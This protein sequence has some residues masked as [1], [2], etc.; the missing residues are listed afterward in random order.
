MFLL[1]WLLPHGV[2]EIPAI[3]V[4]GQAGLVIAYAL[5]G[6]GSRISRAERLRASLARRGDAGRRARGDAGVGGHGGG[7][8]FA[9]SRAGDFL[10]LEDRVRAGG[11]RVAYAISG[12]GGARSGRAFVPARKPAG[13]P[14]ADREVRPTT[15]FMTG[16]NTLVIRTPEG[17]E[18]A[19]P[20]AGPFS[21]M[22]AYSVDLA[23]MGQLRAR[24]SDCSLRC[25]S[26]GRISAG[27]VGVAGYFV[28]SLVYMSLAEWFW[29]GQTVGKRLLRLRVV[30]AGGLRL[31]PPQVI[32]RNLMRFIDALPL[33]YL[34]GG[35]ACVLNRRRQRLGDLA[36]GTVVIR[37]PKL[38]EPDLDQ[39]LGSKYNSL[40]EQRHLAAR[41]RQKATPEIARIAFE[42]V[43]RRDEIEPLRVSLCFRS[44]RITS[45]RWWCI[46]R[47]WW[48]SFP[49]SN[50]FAAWWRCCSR[51]PRVRLR[52]CGVKGR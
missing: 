14:A 24:W 13:R 21:R 48:S 11:G 16:G 33:L 10:W 35:I 38:A 43:L 32:V 52:R 18:F 27:A 3:L 9:V 46:R 30:E 23:V 26:S 8:P 42:A 2:I 29:R 49:M 22:L 5:I 1:G 4:G 25:D 39:L 51:G 28:I 40:A 37:A 34:V 15:F 47:R 19:L 17:V 31:E 36:A 50:T 41:L 6:W 20:L 45:V 44:W 12:E 7:V